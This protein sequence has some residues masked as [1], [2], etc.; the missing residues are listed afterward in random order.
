MDQKPFPNEETINR[1]AEIAGD[2][3]HPEPVGSLRDPGDT[4]SATRRFDQEKHE[5]L[6]QPSTCPH[7]HGEEIS[8]HDQ[9]PV[10][11][12]EL[13]PGCF[14]VAL[15]GRLQSVLLQN[16]RDRSARND[17]SEIR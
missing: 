14:A 6:L 7:F 12:Q 4:D 16:I 5:E 1:V 17:M 13:L 3:A 11:G 8:R 9:F 15:W 10:P 2:L